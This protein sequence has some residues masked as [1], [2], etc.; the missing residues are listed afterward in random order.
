MMLVSV[1]WMALSAI[2]STERK[3]GYRGFFGTSWDAL[4]IRST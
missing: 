2:Q 1:L 4:S 3:R